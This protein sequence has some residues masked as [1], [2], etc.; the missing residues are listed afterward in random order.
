MQC[1]AVGPAEIL[2]RALAADA[3][4]FFLYMKC[5]QIDHW[6]LMLRAPLK[7]LRSWQHPTTWKWVSQNCGY[8]ATVP[9]RRIVT[10]NV[11]K[12]P[13]FE[14]LERRNIPEILSKLNFLASLTLYHRKSAHWRAPILIQK[15][16][17]LLTICRKRARHAAHYIYTLVR[18]PFFQLPGGII[19]E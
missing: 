5:R 6:Q 7:A 1:S 3:D 18:T 2:G 4:A 17:N 16:T 12:M 14:R 8:P 11:R 13:Q 19:H 9:R 10:R 15:I